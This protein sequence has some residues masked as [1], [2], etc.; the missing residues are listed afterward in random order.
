MPI[1]INRPISQSPNAERNV[2]SV[3]N[4][5]KFFDVSI[6]GSPLLD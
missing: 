2:Q 1:Y 4:F 5:V 6:L 3:R